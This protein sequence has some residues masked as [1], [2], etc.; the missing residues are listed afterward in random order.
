MLIPCA[1]WFHYFGRPHAC[2]MFTK[3][4][5]VDLVVHNYMSWDMLLKNH[6]KYISCSLFVHSVRDN[7]RMRQF[8]QDLYN[9]NCNHTR[10]IPLLICVSNLPI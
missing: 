10:S 6:P 3:S 9:A 5:L 2:L 4:S 7:K 1:N 8:L